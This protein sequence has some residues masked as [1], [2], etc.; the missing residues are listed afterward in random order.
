[1]LVCGEEDY[2]MLYQCVCVCKAGGEA[3]LGSMY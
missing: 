2:E 1:M 3:Y